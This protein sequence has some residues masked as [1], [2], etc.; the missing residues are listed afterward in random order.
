MEK[1][2]AKMPSPN[3]AKRSMYFFD[4]CAGIGCFHHGMV[5]AGFSC[6]GAAEFDSD[7]RDAYPPA[8]RI[9][10]SRMFYDLRGLVKTD[11]WLKQLPSMK[12]AVLTAGF[13]CQPFSKGGAQL[14]RSHQEG[15]VFESLMELLVSLDSPA[16]ILENVENLAGKRHQDT[17]LEMKKMI[18]N[19]GYDFAMIKISPHEIGI[20]HNRK[21][22]F[23]VGIKTENKK[24]VEDKSLEQMLINIARN[25][26]IESLWSRKY[27]GG[28]FRSEPITE[29]EEEALNHWDDLLDWASEDPELQPPSPLWG[30]EVRHTY[31]FNKLQVELSRNNNKPLTRKQ[32]LKCLK[33]QARRYA[34]KYTTLE[35]VQKY[36]PPYLQDAH[37]RTEP[38]PD[39][40]PKFAIRSRTYLRDME[41]HL[42]STGRAEQWSDWKKKLGVLKATNQKLEW[43]VGTPPSK[44]RET[45]L[46]RRQIQWRPSGIRISSGVKHPALVAIGQ[47]PAIGHRRT[48]P[49]WTVLARLQS[50]PSDYVPNPK[51][52]KKRRDEIRNLYGQNPVKRLGNSV[53][54]EVVTKIAKLVADRLR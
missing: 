53:N 40:K 38:Y 21:R 17:F 50:I 19:L 44:D 28:N 16:F 43:N 4:A 15:T 9:D 31:E 10:E 20:P 29:V 12:G 1:A 32:L 48:R 37:T 47:V 25:P 30:M 54:V 41:K 35:I 24:G 11:G 26:E 5:A 46:M 34:T 22:W 18:C 8:F 7:I 2:I 39:W 42:R 6:I 36:L 45:R 33:G 49:H 51:H 52:S 3:M 13:P 23:I 14:G 27:L